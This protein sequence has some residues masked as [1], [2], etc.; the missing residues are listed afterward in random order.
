MAGAELPL[1][2][3]EQVGD[4]AREGQR[5]DPVMVRALLILLS[6]RRNLWRILSRGVALSSFDTGWTVCALGSYEADE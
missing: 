4:E 1:S 2:G 6:V 3:A 5:T